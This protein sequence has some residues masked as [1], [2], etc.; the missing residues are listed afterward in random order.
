MDN[1]NHRLLRP[2]TGI[3]LLLVALTFATYGAAELGLQGKGLI[4]GVLLIAIIKGQLVSDRFMGLRWVR[5][6]WRP[7]L[8]GYLLIVGSFIAIAFLLPQG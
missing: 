1:V 8:T 6:F 2:C 3:W 4:L 5:G 7:V